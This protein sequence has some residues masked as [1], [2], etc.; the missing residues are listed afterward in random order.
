MRGMENIDNLQSCLVRRRI[1]RISAT[2]HF[3]L[4]TRFWHTKPNEKKKKKKPWIHVSVRFTQVSISH[5][6]C[7]YLFN[8]PFQS[9]RWDTILTKGV[10][11]H[12]LV[13]H[14]IFNDH[15]FP[16][17]PRPIGVQQ[18]PIHI[19]MDDN[20]SLIPPQTTPPPP[21]L[22]YQLDL[23]NGADHILQSAGNLFTLCEILLAPHISLGPALSVLI[24]LIAPQQTD[25][26]MQL[27]ST[28]NS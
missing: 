2:G 11:P 7:K 26:T 14:S 4:S 12:Y 19:K 1:C 25:T 10:Q 9:C 5:F 16:I 20:F 22:P 24:Q 28:G 3:G 21:S 15:G 8:H 6:L 17:R 23:L 13:T 18:T 27:L